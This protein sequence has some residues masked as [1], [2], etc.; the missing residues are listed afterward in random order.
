M[1]DVNRRETGGNA[2]PGCSYITG[3]GL[4][5]A[6]RAAPPPAEGR[7]GRRDDEHTFFCNTDPWAAHARERA[8]VGTQTLRAEQV[9]PLP[10]YYLPL[11]PHY[12]TLPCVVKRW[13]AG[14]DYSCLKG[15]PTSFG[16]RP[17]PFPGAE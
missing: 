10:N 2:F 14:T 9:Q 13:R 4:N 17:S 3:G 6:A 8:G 7:Y 11:T 1:R 15:R 12:L 16:S 5:D